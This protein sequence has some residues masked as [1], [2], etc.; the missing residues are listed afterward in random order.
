M[1]SDL[2]INMEN[3]MDLYFQILETFIY[4]GQ[5]KKESTSSFVEWSTKIKSF[6]FFFLMNK[7]LYKAQTQ[8]PYTPVKTGN[9]S[10]I[11]Q[12]PS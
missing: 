1:V 3:Q 6:F 11:G 5:L 8:H 2:R 4:F 12:T 7:T 9:K 10:C